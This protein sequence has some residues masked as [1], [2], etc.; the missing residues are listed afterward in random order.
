MSSAPARTLARNT[1]WIRSGPDPVLPPGPAPFDAGCCMNPCAVRIGDAYHLYYAG[2]DAEG[3]RRICLA[4]APVAKP[5]A[6]TRHGPVLDTGAPDSFDYRWVVLPHVVEFTPGR[7]HLYYTA[8]CGKGEGLAAFPGLGLAVSTDGKNWQKCREN[9]VLAPTGKA[10]DPDRY[11]IAGGSVMK[12]RLPGGEREWRFYYTGC[13]TLGADLFSNQQKAACYAVSRDGIQWERRGAILFRNPDRDYENVAC[14]GPV[15]RQEEDG[16]F[17]MWYSM[18]GTRWGAY[19]IGYAESDD[20]IR[21]HRGEYGDNLQLAPAW[22]PWEWQ[23]V[24]YPSVIREG[25]RLR[26]FYCGNGYGLTGIGTALSAPLRA[27]ACPKTRAARLVA[28][29]S[30]CSWLL[31][32]PAAIASAEG[33]FTPVDSQIPA[34]HGPSADGML[35]Q[36]GL[37]DARDGGSKNDVAFR[38]ILTHRNE[39]IEVRL[40]VENHTPRTLHGITLDLALEGSPRQSL[41]ILIGDLPAGE[42]KSASARLCLTDDACRE[43]SL[44]TSEP[45]SYN[46][47]SPWLAVDKKL[48]R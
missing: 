11:G 29:F 30:G 39:G 19:S 20:G 42:N 34:W 3:F 13:P 12:A 45:D 5:G 31:R 27:T 32:L 46:S 23:M 22:N 16:T 36:E 35:W 48:I 28:E 17:R 7:W 10:G 43:I 40:S 37:F 33:S 41:S 15:V 9:P 4:T 44:T 1:W 47:T 26:L 8:N 14:A 38:A 21:W 2:A 18:I 24:E 25:N 6:F